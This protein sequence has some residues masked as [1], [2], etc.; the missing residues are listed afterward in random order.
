MNVA[1]EWLLMTKATM[2]PHQRDLAL[3]ADIAMHQNE[4]QATETIKEA[5]VH[6]AAAIK[7]VEAH[8]AIHAC[9]LEKSH[10]ESMLELEHEVI[11]KEGWEHWAFLEACGAVLC[12]VHPKPMGY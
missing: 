7:E 5:E 3:K 9:T 8:W 1:L 2:D 10:K 6:C 4:A 12:P 11:A